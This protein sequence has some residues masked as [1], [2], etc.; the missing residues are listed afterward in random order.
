[1]ELTVRK[2]VDGRPLFIANTEF[3]ERDIPKDAG[4]KWNPGNRFWYTTDAEI[5]D[6]LREYADE[7]NLAK[8]DAA[9]AAAPALVAEKAV[10]LEAKMAASKATSSDIEI[11]APQGLEYLPFQRAG[12]E[13]ALKRKET[14][15]AD[16]QGLGKTIQVLGLANY[17]LGQRQGNLK[18]L[19]V[20]PKIALRN[21]MREAQKWL[22][23]THSVA[24][25]SAKSQ[26]PAD[27]V[28]VNYDIL[29]KSVIAKALRAQEWDIAAFDEAHALK[30][31]KSKRTL[32]A[33]GRPGSGIEPIKAARRLFLTGTPILNRPIELYPLLS[34]MN[35][36]GCG[37]YFDYARKFCDGRDTRFGFDASGASNLDELQVLLRT[38]VM[39]RRLKKD[40][41]KELP[42]K[43]YAAVELDADTPALRACITAEAR[44]AKESE[45]RTVKL[46]AEIAALKAAKAG[47]A[48][49]KAAMEKLRAGKRADFTE[50]SRLRHETALAKVPGVVEHVREFLEGGE[51]SLLLF[52]HHTDVI[53]ALEAGIKEAGFACAVITGAT[54]DANRQKAQE[55]IQAKRKRVFIGSMRACGVAITLTAASTVIFAEQDWVP[56]IMRQAEDR[57][58]RIGQESAVLVQYLVVDGS[59]DCTM[60]AKVVAKEGVIDAALDG[61][62]EEEEAQT[63]QEIQAIPEISAVDEEPVAVQGAEALEIPAIEA[64]IDAQETAE[65]P[66]IS[67]REEEQSETEIIV[68]PEMEVQ[69]EVAQAPKR[70]RGRP[71]KNG[72][73]MSGADRKRE[74]KARHRV[75]DVE[76]PGALMDRL[77][78]LRDA[79]GL[80]T[81]DLLAAA[82]NALEAADEAQGKRLAA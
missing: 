57:A 51:E 3:S 7:V 76:I 27:I 72:V 58:H 39:V 47:E 36:S 14:L 42:A 18:I 59:F 81:V 63:V 17:L 33:L 26:A 56:G 64:P 45:A 19:I 70:G 71:A 54:S 46:T 61:S 55:D 65:I 20:A 73:A 16:E 74:W 53:A 30:N 62:D 23:R 25:W 5:A 67:E 80:T 50:M 4:F 22:I 69:A 2:T 77:K 41:L 13:Y 75:V 78:A 34:A 31:S 44:F 24:I 29:A 60:A 40:V 82:L 6:E 9:L 1:M 11:P 21:W 12:I 38:S 15:I 66:E 79:R 48:S 10:A 8:L 32:Y 68:P 28:I 52:A 49:V 37:G 43:R 35:V